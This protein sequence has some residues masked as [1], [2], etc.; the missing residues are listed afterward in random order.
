MD[1]EKVLR[2]HRETL[3]RI[4]EV[5]E[6][7]QAELDFRKKMLD[8]M[9]EGRK[10]TRRVKE[11]LVVAGLSMAHTVYSDGLLTGFARSEAAVEEATRKRLENLEIRKELEVELIQYGKDFPDAVKG[12]RKARRALDKILK[13]YEK[14]L[15]SRRDN[16]D[17]RVRE[18]KEL[19]DAN[20][21]RFSH[22]F[23]LSFKTNLTDTETAR[24]IFRQWCKKAMKLY[25]DFI[26][27][28][29]IEWQERGAIHFHCLVGG[30]EVD[31]KDGWIPKDKYNK[32]RKNWSEMK[33]TGEI[34]IVPVKVGYIDPKDRKPRNTDVPDWEDLTQDERYLMIWAFGEYLVTYLEK[35]I[36]DPRLFGKK[37]F[38]SSDK[39]KLS[40]PIVLTAETP[41]E[42]EKIRAAL[43]ELGTHELN[44]KSYQMKVKR[45]NETGNLIVTDEIFGEKHCY[46]KL[47][48]KSEKDSSLE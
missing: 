32:L 8:L 45:Y 19:V 43:D 4:G 48:K 1:I 44:E 27:V 36:D 24:E 40:K 26:Y 29:V 9:Y 22:F 37:L 14:L 12:D 18:F 2:D 25:P 5:A 41:E 28:A 31:R 33:H 16:L 39:K 42:I 35:G 10:N 3:D 11:K 23:T 38:T 6:R 21:H 47:I 20:F 7:Q 13:K 17:R 46:H 30:M 34:H 15:T